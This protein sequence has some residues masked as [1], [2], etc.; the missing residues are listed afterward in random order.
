MKA[1][2]V[3]DGQ[4]ISDEEI[5][6]FSSSSEDNLNSIQRIASN[7]FLFDLTKSAHTL[8]KLQGYIDKITNSYHIFY[9]K[10]EVDV[11]K[12]PVER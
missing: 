3:I 8:S 11:F 1:L 6:Y 5:K 10:D 7:S 4:N 12:Y 2:I 9:L